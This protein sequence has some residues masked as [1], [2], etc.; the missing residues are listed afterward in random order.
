MRCRGGKDAV[1]SNRT[2]EN[3]ER[4]TNKRD[5]VVSFWGHRDTATKHAMKRKSDLQLESWIE[6]SIEY[7]HTYMRANWSSSLVV[8]SFRSAFRWLRIDLES[9]SE[10]RL[11]LPRSSHFFLYDWFGVRYLP[12]VWESWTREKSWRRY[13]IARALMT[14]GRISLASRNSSSRGVC[15]GRVLR[16]RVLQKKKTGEYKK[17][18][19]K[20]TEYMEQVARCAA[21]AAFAATVYTIHIF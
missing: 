21:T 5:C 19:E 12:L 9:L 7:T 6:Q 4:N 20:R 18:K 16:S 10:S 2:S 15:G 11:T 8:F 3:N 14:L 17:G 1:N 13:V